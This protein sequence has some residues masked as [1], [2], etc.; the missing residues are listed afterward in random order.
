MKPT[1]AIMLSSLIAAAGFAEVITLKTGT[2]LTGEVSRVGKSIVE[3]RSGR[4]TSYHSL[5]DLKLDDARRIAPD[6]SPGSSAKPVQRRAPAR[7]ARQESVHPPA[8]ET[9]NVRGSEN[10][11]ALH[12]VCASG[13]AQLAASL[14]EKGADISTVDTKHNQPLHAAAAAGQASVVRLLLEKGADI[15][16]KGDYDRMPLHAAARAGAIEVAEIL[17]AAGADINARSYENEAPLHLAA[18]GGHAEMIRFL[19]EHDAYP[20]ILSRGNGSALHYAAATGSL[21]AVEALVGAGLDVNAQDISGRTPLHYA[22]EQNAVELTDFLIEKGAETELYGRGYGIHDAARVLCTPLHVAARFSYPA[23]VK[24]L[25][26]HG[27]DPNALDSVGATPLHEAA[28]AVTAVYAGRKDDKTEVLRMLAA[29]CDIN[30]ANDE[31]ETPL[32]CLAQKR[33]PYP[34]KSADI[35][36]QRGA[37]VNFED[38]TGRTALHYAVAEGYAS[39]VSRL[40]AS[41]ANQAIRDFE[42]RLPS[43]LDPAKKPQGHHSEAGLDEPSLLEAARKRDLHLVQHLVARGANV[44]EQDEAGNTPLHRAIWGDGINRDDIEQ[45][46]LEGGADPKM[47]NAA[48]RTP[49]HTAMG[50]L[51]VKKVETLVAGGAPLNA[52]DRNRDTA[53]HLAAG[54]G[55]WDLAE[56]LLKAGAD[57]NLPN[58]EG[59]TPLHLAS[60]GRKPEKG[61]PLLLRHGAD[62]RRVNAKGL[63]PPSLAQTK[64]IKAAIKEWE[65][66]GITP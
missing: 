13:N 43:D 32:I 30:A 15:H 4:S 48:G 29:V 62:P 53:L 5:S 51:S 6:F 66:A 63:T 57:P 20:G 34:E 42:G 18:E 64:G 12:Q 9:S 46:L 49:L 38:R 10:K 60:T 35:L 1:V 27:A 26:K 24:L 65:K 22:V 55:K 47:T 41:G 17:L 36:I 58:R 16:A 52:Q 61:I 23:V 59:N 14:I 8:P 56:V 54:Y 40:T 45:I 2:I 39:L 31:G 25:L 28:S 19:L 50:M 11:S 44:N 37:D 33:A 3:M 21:S 7:A